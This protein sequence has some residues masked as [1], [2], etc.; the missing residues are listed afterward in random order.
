MTKPQTNGAPTLWTNPV[1]PDV[2]ALALPRLEKLTYIVLK[3]FCPHN[4]G[5]FRITP[6][7][8]A[9]HIS[10]LQLDEDLAPK[11]SQVRQAITN[12]HTTGLLVSAG[13]NII[14]F[15]ERWLQTN[16]PNNK[17]HAATALLHIANFPEIVPAFCKHY[18]IN[19][20]WL[21]LYLP[22]TME[23]VSTDPKQTEIPDPNGEVTAEKPLSNP[24][25]KKIKKKIKTKTEKSSSDDELPAKLPRSKKSPA[26]QKTDSM[27]REN[28][29]AEEFDIY[30]RFPATTKNG[31]STYACGY[32]Q[33]LKT[34]NPTVNQRRKFHDNLLAILAMAKASKLSDAA[35]NHGLQ[36]AGSCP[37]NALKYVKNSAVKFALEAKAKAERAEPDTPD[38][39][40]IA[41]ARA[42]K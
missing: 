18:K 41:A 40:T 37:S 8:L 22:D 19:P 29:D 42:G 31:L 34:E 35:L 5:V 6:A 28:L 12:L 10:E 26:V 21:T 9:G 11:S 30:A 23:I 33:L 16:N 14:W 38:A 4:S 24:I 32:W 27:I 39:A 7:V 25:K 20:D 15:K 13:N 36:A 2:L 17:I 1:S 3:I